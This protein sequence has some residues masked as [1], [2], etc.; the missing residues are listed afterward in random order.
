M[1]T[2]QKTKLLDQWV[3]GTWSIDAEGFVN[4]IGDVNTFNFY[5]YQTQ[6]KF[7]NVSGYFYCALNKLKTLKSCPHTVGGHFDC[8]DNKLTTLEGSPHT[9]GGS[10]Y[11]K[12]NKLTTLEGMSK[13]IKGDFYCSGNN[14]IKIDCKLN[15]RLFA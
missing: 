12:N 9:V 3:E 1:T 5:K 15:G 6:I 13:I 10:F 8:S 2:N 7:G 11:C 4:V 14:L